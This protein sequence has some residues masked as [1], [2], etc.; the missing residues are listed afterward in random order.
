MEQDLEKISSVL[1]I[2]YEE[3]QVEELRRRWL[4]NPQEREE[5][6]V[7]AFSLGVEAKLK[8]WAIPFFSGRDYKQ[9]PTDLLLVQ[10]EML[11][12]FF[13]SQEWQEFNY[14]G[15]ALTKVF[16]FMF[17]LYFHRV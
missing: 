13:S 1:V 7:V 6:S 9:I 4:K 5:S 3:N 8:E 12:K 11:E 17:R 2:L 16:Q 15:V 14:R 10:D